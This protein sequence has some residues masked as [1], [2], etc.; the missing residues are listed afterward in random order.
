MPDSPSSRNLRPSD[1]RQ[2]LEVRAQAEG[3]APARPEVADEESVCLKAA[4]VG[5]DLVGVVVGA[6]G[7][8]G[9]LFGV[10][11]LSAASVG[12]LRSN[13]RTAKNAKTLPSCRPAYSTVSESQPSSF[14]SF[15]AS[16][17]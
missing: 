10:A 2:R 6:D 15:L 13:L 12:G 3:V 16:A 1:Y 7:K 11:H 4:R 9:Q 14:A 8:V 17:K 5:G